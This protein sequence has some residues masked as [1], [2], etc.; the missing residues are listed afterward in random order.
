MLLKLL[1]LVELRLLEVLVD[2]VVIVLV[3]NVVSV[4][5]VLLVVVID[6]LLDVVF[7]VVVTH[8]VHTSR[9]HRWQS[10]PCPPFSTGASHIIHSRFHVTLP[11]PPWHS[12]EAN[13]P[14]GELNVLHVRH[15]SHCWSAF[16]KYSG[17]HDD[18]TLHVTL[19]LHPMH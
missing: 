18:Q 1:V 12:T 16:K 14:T 9:V 7:V 5:E 11:P 6:V 19:S 2:V 15:A 17:W 4:P 8:T 3:V 13:S 10:G